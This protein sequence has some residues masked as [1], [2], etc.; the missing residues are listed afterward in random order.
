ML[1]VGLGVL[2]VEIQVAILDEETGKHVAQK[3]LQRYLVLGLVWVWVCL[4][5]CFVCW[6]LG[7]WGGDCG[8]G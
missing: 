2:V 4:L 5:F 1:G 3:I 7:V 8:V 6:D